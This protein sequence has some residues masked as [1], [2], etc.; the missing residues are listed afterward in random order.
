M[1]S[2]IAFFFVCYINLPFL[3]H[4]FRFPTTI[5]GSQPPPRHCAKRPAMQHRWIYIAIF[6]KAYASSQNLQVPPSFSD[7]FPTP[8]NLT[9]DSFGSIGSCGSELPADSESFDVSGLIPRQ[10]SDPESL[11]T[12]T[13]L[14]DLEDPLNTEDL[15][16]SGSVGDLAMDPAQL[17]FDGITPQNDAPSKD[18]CSAEP[19]AEGK[20]EGEP[21]W[22]PIDPGQPDRDC[23][24]D[25][26]DKFCCPRGIVPLIGTDG[27][28]ACKA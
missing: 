5:L 10:A 3:C 27:C 8:I 16:S 1:S 18:I 14:G 21:P 12:S 20:G 4:F 15:W 28:V 17:N 2:L 11:Y 19:P 13:D 7:P 9:P 22:I 26:W 23:L 25:N 6:Y 24:D